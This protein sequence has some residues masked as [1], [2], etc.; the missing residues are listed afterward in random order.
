MS[1]DKF[2]HYGSGRDGGDFF[3]GE[4]DDVAEEFQEAYGFRIG[5]GTWMYPLKER[6]GVILQHRQLKNEGGVEDGVGV[7][8]EGEDVAGFAAA[9]AVPAKDRVFRGD[10]ADPVVAD[11]PSQE[12]VVRC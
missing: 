4:G 10:A 5:G 11:H 3:R 8:L 7:F 2:S 9:D 12:T 1:A 6:C